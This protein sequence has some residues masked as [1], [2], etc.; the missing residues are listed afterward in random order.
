MAHEVTKKEAQG[1]ISDLRKHTFAHCPGLR[2]GGQFLGFEEQRVFHHADPVPT[3]LMD[4]ERFR[5]GCEMARSTFGFS[6]L[7]TNDGSKRGFT[8][9]LLARI[10]RDLDELT[11]YQLNLIDPMALKE[12]EDLNG[13]DEAELIEASEIT[14]R[15]ATQA[16]RHIYVKHRYSL[17]FGS[18]AIYSNANKA[19]LYC[20]PAA[21]VRV[22]ALESHSGTTTLSVIEPIKHES[23]PPTDSVEASSSFW[24]IVK[25]FDHNFKPFDHNFGD[26]I[27]WH[28][29]ASQVRAIMRTLETGIVM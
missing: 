6:A 13:V 29:A 10:E 16:I 11:P 5:I 27:V 26:G 24:E 14:F 7:S 23:L 4:S 2:R 12:H 8:F 17:S 18:V 28:S 15:V 25:P 9:S 22:P 21:E 19:A 20:V 1:L 3:E